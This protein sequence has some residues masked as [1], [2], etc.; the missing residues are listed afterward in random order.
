M[1]LFVSCARRS[2]FDAKCSSRSNWSSG[3]LGGSRLLGA[4]LDDGW[5]FYTGMGLGIE[6]VM[7]AASLTLLRREPVAG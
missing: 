7:L 1:H 3:G 6:F 4:A 5:S 2:R